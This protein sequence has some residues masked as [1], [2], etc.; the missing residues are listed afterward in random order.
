MLEMGR[1]A[2]CRQAGQG[3][4]LDETKTVSAPGI[5]IICQNVRT[6]VPDSLE[7]QL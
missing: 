3:A 4:Q 7:L 5:T 1:G 6:L 2:V